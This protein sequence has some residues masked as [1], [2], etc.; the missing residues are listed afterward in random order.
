MKQ[1]RCVMSK[2]NWKFF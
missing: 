2:F 1:E